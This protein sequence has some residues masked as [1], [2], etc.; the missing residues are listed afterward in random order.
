MEESSSNGS[1]RE[2]SSGARATAT[3]GADQGLDPDQGLALDQGLDPDADAPGE[4]AQ[5]ARAPLT[6]QERAAKA[7]ISLRYHLHWQN[8]LGALGALCR[9]LPAWGGCLLL[10]VR[11]WWER[12]VAARLRQMLPFLDHRHRLQRLEQVGAPPA[13]SQAIGFFKTC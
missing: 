6:P 3:A 10:A 9:L 5:A 13:S 7:Q 4:A 11:G 2:E 8:Y 12:Q 1:G